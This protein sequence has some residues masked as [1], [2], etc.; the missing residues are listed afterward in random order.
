MKQPIENP[1]AINLTY[2]F[3]KKKDGLE[4]IQTGKII[5]Q[6]LPEKFKPIQIIHEKEETKEL[7]APIKE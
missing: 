1:T 5:A 6:E 4:C 2:V 3:L 7:V